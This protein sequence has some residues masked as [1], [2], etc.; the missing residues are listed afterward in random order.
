MPLPLHG[1]SR[2]PA[3]TTDVRPLFAQ[4][5]AF[6]AIKMPLTARTPLVVDS[7]L[8]N[9]RSPVRKYHTCIPRTSNSLGCC[10]CIYLL[11]ACTS[12]LLSAHFLCCLHQARQSIAQCTHC[13]QTGDCSVAAVAP[14]VSASPPP[15]LR[16][17]APAI[18]A[19][20]KACKEP[21]DRI[22]LYRTLKPCI[23]RE[24]G[25]TVLAEVWSTGFAVSTPCTATGASKSQSP[26]CLCHA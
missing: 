2:A 20:S 5:S 7:V 24:C 13:H 3:A 19:I 26:S 23:S 25:E 8:L 9:V 6:R 16:S 12:H 21:G 15:S 22:P 1:P 11:I 17:P 10:I 18:A 14:P 4:S